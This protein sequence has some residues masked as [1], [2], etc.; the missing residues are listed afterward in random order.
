MIVIL[1]VNIIVIVVVV[2]SGDVGRSTSHLFGHNSKPGEV[3]VIICVYFYVL[4]CVAIHYIY[5]C[6]K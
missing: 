3:L 1:I 5:V 6:E 2:D 4:L